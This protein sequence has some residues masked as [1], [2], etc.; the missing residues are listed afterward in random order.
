[1][2]YAERLAD[3]VHR[4]E[5][6]VARAAEQRDRLADDLR[7]WQRPIEMVERG[8]AATRFLRAH[9]ALVALALVVV[10]VLGRRRLLR[11]LGRG[12][13]VWRSWRAMQGWV[14]LLSAR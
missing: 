9:P 3:V 5:R 2:I 4:K 7:A 13:V 6:L 10:A 14:R 8:I 11:W 1:M 12:L